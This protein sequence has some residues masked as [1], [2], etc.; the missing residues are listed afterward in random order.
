MEEE[1]E[2]ELGIEVASS[3]RLDLAKLLVMIVL[4][5]TI[6]AVGYVV[7]T[8]GYTISEDPCKVAIERG[9]ICYNPYS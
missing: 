3:T 7:Y 9:W 4:I 2:E 8:Y 5:I 6:L 1:Q